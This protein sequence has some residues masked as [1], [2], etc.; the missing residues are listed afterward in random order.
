M[1]SIGV[2]TYLMVCGKPPFHGETQQEILAKI[3]AKNKKIRYPKNVKLSK[4]CKHFIESL[5]CDDIGKRLNAEEAL[6]HPWLRVAASDGQL[7]DDYLSCLKKYKYSNELQN[8][9]MRAML[10]NIQCDQRKI[11]NDGLLAM[12]RKVSQMNGDSVVDYLLLNCNQ[13][14]RVSSH[15]DSGFDWDNLGGLD[16]DGILDEIEEE[17]RE[18]G[19]DEDIV[20]IDNE[21]EDILPKLRNNYSFVN[22]QNSSVSSYSMT[23]EKSRSISV[24]R[25]KYILKR[26]SKQYDIDSIVDDLNLD[27]QIA[28]DDISSYNKTIKILQ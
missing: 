6:K 3:M 22:S 4:S 11:L 18:I 8:I 19:D 9:L 24:D 21:S 10:K 13:S 26:A 12:N 14:Q 23:I 16:V 28:F 25:F 17:T 27:G 1:W 7:S 15:F 5:L 2:I 20:D